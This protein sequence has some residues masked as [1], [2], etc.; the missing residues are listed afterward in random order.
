MNRVFVCLL[1]AVQTAQADAPKRVIEEVIVT[2]QKRAQSSQDV[3]ISISAFD[4]DFMKDVGATNLQDIAAYIPNLQFSSDTDPALA[5][6]NIRGFGTNPVNV[7]FETSVGF[8]Q[9]ELFF[10]RPGYFS[11]AIFDIGR[12]EVLRGPQGTLFGKNTVA[13]VFNV[14][15]AEPG[16]SF[17][18][19]IRVSRAD[20]EEK[21]MEFGVGG[22]LSEKVGVR[23]SGLAY[24]KEGDLQNTKRNEKAD[25][26]EQLAG[27]MKLQFQPTENLS[28]E[29]TVIKSDTDSGYWSFQLS[30]LD[31]GTRDFVDNYDPEVE[32]DPHNHQLSHNAAGFLDKGSNTVGLKVDWDLSQLLGLN[33][34]VSTLVV[35]SSELYFRE[36][37]DLDASPAD[38][39]KLGVA[40]DFEQD[41]LE[42]R[43]TGSRDSG[44]WGLG[45]SVEYVVG[46]FYF[47]SRFEQVV[48]IV[49]G[50]DFGAYLSTDDAA[51]LA[52]GNN[53]TSTGVGSIPGLGGL[54]GAGVGAAIGD[55]RYRLEYLLDI[56]ALAWFGQMTWYLNENWAITPGIRYNRERKRANAIGSGLCAGKSGGAP[57]IIETAL[58]AQDY[59]VIGITREETDLSPK[60]SLQY[61][62]GDDLTLFFTYARGFKSG[63]FNGASFSGDDLD[64]EPEEART[65]EMGAKGVFLDQ[66]LKLNLTLFH[67]EFDNL[68]VLAFN[69][70]FF[71][72]T[73]AA[74]AVSEGIEMDF[75]W[76][77]PLAF[78]TLSGSAGVLNAEYD[79]YANAPAPI[80]Q[81]INTTQDVGGERVALAPEASASL[82]PVVNFPL[83]ANLGLRASLDLLYQG[84][85]FTDIDLDPE[86]RI[87]AHTLVSARVSVGAQDQ[88][89]SLSLGG[90][91][92][93]D[94]D[95]S[96]QV[97]DTVFFPGSYQATQKGGRKVFLALTMSW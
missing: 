64:F 90:S 31:D 66:S 80:S 69:G 36:L 92:L 26:Y 56:E 9:D 67:T 87:P 40:S 54:I 7:A 10:G 75:T 14:T 23:L 37:I 33:D 3:P 97:L 15:S 25:R 86:T 77:T 91:N 70:A 65:F 81:G 71:D 63:G 78:L 32:D 51:Q 12:V 8:V 17:S 48:D 61:F 85:Q 41:S 84:E 21:R 96:N 44:L 74:S 27:R 58:S 18:G 59:R 68:Q 22:P 19:D 34:L 72:V 35:G 79:E 13:G 5:Q 53:G 43:F 46:G 50:E 16:E 6:I 1:L 20:P 57:C 38:V 89:W 39:A 82:S 60:L 42:L 88:S 73:N 49:A 76:L 11:E 2:A 47:E 52:S 55:D 62:H 28:S 24:E 30:K 4:G 29:L 45:S 83:T 95:V 94:K 93:T